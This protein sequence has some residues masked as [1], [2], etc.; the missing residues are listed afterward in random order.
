MNQNQ[1]RLFVDR[2]LHKR[3]KIINELGRGGMGTVYEALDLDQNNAHVAIKQMLPRDFDLRAAFEREAD[4]LS[5]LNHSQLPAVSN[6]FE[7]E[8]GLFMA[9]QFIPGHNL[10]QLLN[11]RPLPFPPHQVK[12][13]AEDLLETLDYL[14]SREPQIIHRDIKPTN[15]KLSATGR[16][17]LLDFGLAR[18]ITTNDQEDPAP[19]FCMIAYTPHYA[20]PEQIQG[21]Q[22][23]RYSD[24]YALGATLYH[25][26][27]GTPPVDALKRLNEKRNNS[28]DPLRPI[29][30]VMKGVPQAFALVIMRA[31]SLD[32]EQRPQTAADMLAQLKAGTLA[33]RFAPENLTTQ[34]TLPDLITVAANPSVMSQHQPGLKLAQPTK[35]NI[36][37]PTPVTAQLPER[38]KNVLAFSRFRRHQDKR[39]EQPNTNALPKV[40]NLASAILIL[41]TVATLARY[42]SHSFIITSGNESA[43]SQTQ[44]IN[45]SPS[46]NT[47]QK[48]NTLAARNISYVAGTP[49]LPESL[50][51]DDLAR[52]RS[53]YLKS[54]ARLKP[55]MA[56][57]ALPPGT[58]LF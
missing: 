47:D 2:V 14:H 9:M 38:R 19:D 51:L 16:I 28:T 44:I 17:V 29:S 23:G 40:A 53:R 7:E 39:D 35:I 12:A 57:I 22:T 56:T 41:I 42:V 34:A 6:L 8:T 11:S 58:A 30:E 48:R 36:Q 3:Y 24:I 15:L 50:N 37:I 13:W 18:E 26:I 45:E 33:A 55:I 43:A 25:L 54:K 1:L 32:P 4:I 21:Q 46:T 52:Y 10:G 31:L 49:Q 20:P 27:T 5:R